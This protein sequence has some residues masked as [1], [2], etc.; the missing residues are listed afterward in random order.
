M[1]SLI[2]DGS[3]IL[4]FI[5]IVVHYTHR[6]FVASVVGFLRFWI[7]TGIATLFSGRVGA[8]LQPIIEARLELE[9]N[10]S[11]FSNLLQQIVHSGYL[12]K[13]IAFILIF[14]AASLFVKL[15]EVI[16][17]AMTKLPFVNFINRMLG[18]GM[19]LVIG[20]FWVELIAFAVV[21]LADYLNEILTFLPEGAIRDTVVLHWLYEHNIFRWI[22][23]RLLTALGH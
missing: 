12:S 23:D 11:F 6:G 20:F 14:I 7:A 10:G 5:L 21:S 2:I 1:G 15:I 17:N 22:V 18:M 3:V 13:A 9:E 16:M 4:I 8:S 19:G